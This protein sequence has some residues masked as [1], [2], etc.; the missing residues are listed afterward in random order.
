[1]IG[2]KIPPGTVYIFTI[3]PRVCNCPADPRVF[4]T[5][6]VLDRIVK[7]AN[8]YHAVYDGF[9]GDQLMWLD[10]LIV[11]IRDGRIVW[12]DGRLMEGINDGESL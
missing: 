5:A 11:D 6:R 12:R 10:F 8:G 2:I 3:A 7:T 9:F 1:M 4:A